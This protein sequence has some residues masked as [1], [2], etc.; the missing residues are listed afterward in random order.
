MLLGSS[1]RTKR[2]LAWTAAVAVA[3]VPAAALAATDGA[4]SP[5]ALMAK[6]KKSGEEQDIPGVVSCVVPNERGLLVFLMGIIPIE[7]AGSVIAASAQESGEQEA[8]ARAIALRDAYT[9]LNER[10]GVT[11]LSPEQDLDLT[12]PVRSSQVLDEK[13]GQ[14]DHAGFI[15][16]AKALLESMHPNPDAS[17]SNDQFGDE[18][19]NIDV[20]GDTAIVTFEKNAE[21]MQLVQRDGRWYI[22]LIP[23]GY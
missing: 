20:A 2:I 11:R 17:S 8:Q 6:L 19:K 3:A 7:M 14:I 15:A 13:L 4:E 9:A 1:A 10:Y 21:Q 16:D 12:D 5:A 18:V 23:P 22:R